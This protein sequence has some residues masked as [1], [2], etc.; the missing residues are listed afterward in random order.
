MSGREVPQ[1][2]LDD[3]ER[4]PAMPRRAEIEAAN[5]AQVEE[6]RHLALP[7]LVRHA[8]PAYRIGASPPPLPQLVACLEGSAVESRVAD[9]A[10]PRGRLLLRCL[11]PP[12]LIERLHPD[13][14]LSAFTRTPEREHAV[15]ER[16]ARGGHASVAVA[17]TDAGAI[18][19]T[20]VLASG[21]D[22]WRDLPGVYELSIETSRDWRGLGVARGLLEFCVGAP[23]L[24]HLI[25]LAMGLDWHWNLQAAGL[26]APAYGAM[27]RRLFVAAGFEEM[28]TSEPNVAMHAPNLLLIR[29][30]AQV[31]PSDRDALKEARYVAPW[32]R[33][34][35]LSRV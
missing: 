31:P 13:P 26:D 7:A 33:T 27:L 18:V 3:P 6:V 17:H 34:A 29:V 9:L 2:V 35:T 32:L 16:L 25:A 4:W 15:L 8:F 19:G 14:G 20:V 10:T 12:S 22:W 24:E 5:H 21:E 1:T 11:C 28:R 23:W 30:G